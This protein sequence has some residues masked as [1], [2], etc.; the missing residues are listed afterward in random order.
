MNF[1]LDENFQ[2]SAHFYLTQRGHSCIDVRD[3]FPQGAEDGELFVFAQQHRAIFLTT[4][5]DFYHTI[6]FFIFPHHGVVVISLRQP[7]RRIIQERLQWFLENTPVSMDNTVY[8]LRD[9]TFIVA[10]NPYE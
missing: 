2:K 6:P 3:H 8:L 5:K 9:R 10:K 4:D 1:C 7:N